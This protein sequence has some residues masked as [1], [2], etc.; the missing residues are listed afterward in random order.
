LRAQ[1]SAAIGADL[2]FLNMEVRMLAQRG[3]NGLSKSESVGRTLRAC[4]MGREKEQER[5]GK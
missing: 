5:E 1:Q 3:L 2:L 4:G